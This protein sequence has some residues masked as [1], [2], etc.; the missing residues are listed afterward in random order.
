ME[1]DYAPPPPGY[2]L[3][4][5]EAGTDIDVKHRSMTIILGVTNMLNTRYR[6]YLN[7]FRYFSD[8]MGRNISLRVKVPFEFKTKP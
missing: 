1:S 7:A 4:G 5:F 3:A 2:T 6:D 8:D